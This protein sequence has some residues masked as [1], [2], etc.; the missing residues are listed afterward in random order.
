M[1]D[2]MD[3]AGAYWARAQARAEQWQHTDDYR[4]GCQAAHAWAVA[5]MGGK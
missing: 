3:R 2:T 4:R 1:G 5:A